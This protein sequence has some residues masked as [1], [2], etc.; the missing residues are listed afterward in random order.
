MP[1]QSRSAAL[2]GRRRAFGAVFAGQ[3]PRVGE[4]RS[5]CVSAERA[6]ARETAPTLPKATD[7]VAAGGWAA[8]VGRTSGHGRTPTHRTQSSSV[9][10]LRLGSRRLDRRRNLTPSPNRPEPADATSLFASAALALGCRKAVTA[11]TSL[12]ARSDAAAL[13]EARAPAASRCAAASSAWRSAPE[14]S[15]CAAESEARIP[16]VVTAAATRLAACRRWDLSATQRASSMHVGLD[17]PPHSNA[18]GRFKI[19]HEPCSMPHSVAAVELCGRDQDSQF[20]TRRQGQRL[21]GEACAF[22]WPSTCAAAVVPRNGGLTWSFASMLTPRLG[23]RSTAASLPCTAA[24]INFEFTAFAQD[25]VD[26][27]HPPTRRRQL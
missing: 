1:R 5:W 9:V 14:L 19:G 10:N 18:V 6:S 2:T 4:C 16:T 17:S 3:W 11:A 22:T 26:T 7:S 25:G 20:V 8:G 13:T 12:L 23:S 15:A 21:C 24:G 27:S